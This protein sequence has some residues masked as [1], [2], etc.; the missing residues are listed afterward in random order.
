MND[1]TLELSGLSIPVTHASGEEDLSRDY[2]VTVTVLFDGADSPSPREVL[3]AEARLVLRSFGHERTYSGV[4]QSARRDARHHAPGALTLELVPRSALL[5]VGQCSRSFEAKSV[6]EVATTILDEVR[7]P[8]RVHVDKGAPRPHLAQYRES[9]RTFITRLLSSEGIFTWFDHE[10]ESAPL[11]LCDRA[12]QNH[13]SLSVLDS[14]L[15]WAPDSG[16]VATEECILHAAFEAEVRPT[17]IVVGSFDYRRPNLPILERA[18]T[19]KLETYIPVGGARSKDPGGVRRHAQHLLESED[20]ARRTLAGQTTSI[21][22]TVGTRFRVASDHL[23]DEYTVI[24]TRW[25]FHGRRRLAGREREL[26]FQRWFRASVGDRPIRAT[27]RD[28]ASVVPGLQGAMVMSHPAR[29]VHP[30]PDARV[31]ARMH[32]DLRRRHDDSDG[33]WMRVLQRSSASSLLT[34]RA[35]WA[36]L[37]SWE[38]GHRETPYVLARIFDAEHRPP[39]SLPANKTRFVIKTA[40]SPVE[41]SF[42]EVMFE[43]AEGREELLVNASRDMNVVVGGSLSSSV[44]HDHT[45]LIRHDQAVQTVGSH[46]ETI[47]GDQTISVAAKE[48]IDGTR[49]FAE[50]IKG[51]VVEAVGGTRLLSTT[52]NASRASEATRSVSVGAAQIDATLGDV[53]Y[54]SDGPF[55]HVVGGAHARLA[56]GATRE[57]LGDDSRELVGAMRMTK[58]S[59]CI[60]IAGSTTVTETVGSNYSAVLGKRFVDGAVDGATWTIAASADFKGTSLL[61]EAVDSIELVCGGSLIRI[62]PDS[63]LIEAADFYTDKANLVSA[64]TTLIT[65]NC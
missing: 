36:V 22:L 45:T 7:M 35:G 24:S 13:G 8:F 51:S 55:I 3:G 6:V 5:S 34:P 42:N 16:E 40:T 18:G 60:I 23:E 21:R 9:D 39:Y 43:D 54:R 29:E 57:S 53:S 64:A 20:M 41:A 62:L 14:P 37:T 49:T 28:K 26:P 31:K 38:A 52:S 19:G 30:D 12:G 47:L 25:Q 58:A 65:H 44:G 46:Q 61:V 2:R 33:K 27:S 1:S 56:K 32:W 59:D 63:V 17:A 11:L 15:P 10:D 50:H 4:I 48:T